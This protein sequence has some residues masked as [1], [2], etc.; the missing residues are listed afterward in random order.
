MAKLTKQTVF[1]RQQELQ[2]ATTAETDRIIDAMNANH[3][4]MIGLINALDVS[5]LDEPLVD[6][7]INESNPLYG[8]LKFITT[9]TAL[10]FIAATNLSDTLKDAIIGIIGISGLAGPS[11]SDILKAIEEIDF[12]PTLSI[13]Y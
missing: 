3:Q 9:R 12:E 5:T 7:L 8:T 11:N 10:L 4:E 6:G 2:D 13:G 1:E